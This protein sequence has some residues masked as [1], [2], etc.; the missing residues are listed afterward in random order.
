MEKLI[1]FKV[2][3]YSDGVRRPWSNAHQTTHE[4]KA[5]IYRKK[6]VNHRRSECGPMVA[7]KT[8]KDAN[9]F[10]KCNGRRGD[11]YLIAEIEAKLSKDCT[12]WQGSYISFSNWLP[13][14]TIFI[15]SFKIIN[16]TVYD[17]NFLG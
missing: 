10:I 6:V 5:I 9:N 14:G 7:F 12:L 8:I 3:D 16:E 11:E 13:D 17:G 4:G 2:F 1:M 15:D